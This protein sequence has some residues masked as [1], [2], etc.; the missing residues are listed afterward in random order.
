MEQEPKSGLFDGDGTEV[1]AD[2]ILKPSLCVSCRK[3]DVPDEEIL[4]ALTR[5]DQEGEKEFTCFAFEPRS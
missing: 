2:L 1:N 3:D 4:C 5:A